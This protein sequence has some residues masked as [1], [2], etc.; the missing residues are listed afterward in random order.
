MTSSTQA[1]V[2]SQGWYGDPAHP[3]Q[4]RFWDGTAWTRV[5]RRVQTLD[6]LSDPALSLPLA[7]W[8]RRFGSGVLD[9]VIAWV[10]S[11]MVLGISA[12]DAMTRWQTLFSQYGTD[13][14][15]AARHGRFIEPSDEAVSAAATLMLIVGVV[16]VFYTAI[17]LG[18]RGA[19]LGHQI[20]GVK[21]VKAPL[22]MR[23]LSMAGNPPFHEEK[24]GWM[25]SI[26]KGLGWALF[27]T[28]TS[29]FAFI[30]I[31]NV[32]LP[33]W[34]PRKQSVTDFFASTLLIRTNTPAASP[35]EGTHG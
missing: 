13:V 29:W 27:S 30:Q 24:P 7:G 25:R 9:T 1:P 2:P 8:W 33:L 6:K 11:L 10:L 31:V 23:W 20:M 16:M 17:M 32:V 14:M 22:P 28:G 12:P 19:T 4:E 35:Q 3:G 26:S 21:V 5:V 18:F 34:H 15:I